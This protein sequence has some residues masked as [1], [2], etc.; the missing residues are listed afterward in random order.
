MNNQNNKKRDEDE[1]A[2]AK[3]RKAASRPGVV[4]V[5]G[6]EAS[7]LDQRIAEKR[8]GDVKP[9]PEAVNQ[10]QQDVHAKQRKAP[11]ASQPGAV[12]AHL[13]SLEDQVAAKTA[14]GL[15]KPP[16]SSLKPAPAALT[17]LE[18]RISAKMAMNDRKPAAVEEDRKP[19]AVDSTKMGE[20]ALQGL[21]AA[22]ASK[23]DRKYPAGG[24][25]EKEKETEVKKLSPPTK[26][27]TSPDTAKMPK[28]DEGGRGLGLLDDADLE[29][30]VYD[31]ADNPDGLAVAVPVPE[32]DENV[33]IPSA[34]EYDPDAKPPVHQSKRFRMYAFLALFLL[35]LVGVGAGVGIPLAK[36]KREDDQPV[37]YRETLGIRE[38]VERV[39]GTEVLDDESS[40]SFKAL[41][42]ITFN[43]PL[44]LL[45]Q[46]PVFLQRF[47]LAD[48]YFST[49][50]ERPWDSCNPPNLEEGEDDKCVYG[51]L[52]SLTPTVQRTPRAGS[53]RWVSGQHECEWV[54]VTCDEE[55]QVRDV[56][57]SK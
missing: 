32:E 53:V 51:K 7:R 38:F 11:P 15:K 17:S 47:L 21:E 34:V 36:N 57:L 2:K 22:V 20:D 54:G 50:M 14:G 3:P 42:W 56:D 4:A 35:V 30:G 46:N 5:S 28:E 37:N 1:K 23:T 10:L 18:D 13:D 16:P 25:K 9:P 45:P 19:A 48:F 44:Q 40:P 8:G 12:R 24:E 41:R 39:I 29:Y 31:A 52:E 33:F 26:K 27:V 43:D 6:E 55:N 49:S